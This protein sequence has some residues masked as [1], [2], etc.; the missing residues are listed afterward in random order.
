[1]IRINEIQ[2]QY[3]AYHLKALK[4]SLLGINVGQ[5]P[6]VPVMPGT[7]PAFLAPPS[8]LLWS[9]TLLPISWF[10][11]VPSESRPSF[12][13]LLCLVYVDFFRQI[14][15]TVCVVWNS[16]RKFHVCI[17]NANSFTS[18]HL[19]SWHNACLFCGISVHGGYWTYFIIGIYIGIIWYCVCRA[20][21]L[22]LILP[23]KYLLGSGVREEI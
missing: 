12:C 18:S 19:W 16:E 2:H 14:L 23:C 22:L 10:P 4:Y 7:S 8:L 21:M 17:L 5:C 3:Q 13:S 9:P 20:F 1:M 11:A 15:S 6:C